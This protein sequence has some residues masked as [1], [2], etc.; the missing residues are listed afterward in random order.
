MPDVAPRT[1][2]FC[3]LLSS[4]YA[5][6][7]RRRHLG[8]D[9]RNK[10]PPARVRRFKQSGTHA[11]ILGGIERATTLLNN[12]VKRL[13]QFESALAAHGEIKRDG[14]SRPGK[15]KHSRRWRTPELFDHT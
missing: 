6:P 9:I 15:R 14:K 11:R 8:I 2:T 12:L 7:E 3:I 13:H 1:T 4:R 5:P 10:A